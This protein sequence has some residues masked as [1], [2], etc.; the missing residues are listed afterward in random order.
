[1]VAANG[2]SGAYPA[3]AWLAGVLPVEARRFRVADA[4]LADTL[5]DAGADLVATAPDVEIGAVRNLLGD[6]PMAIVSINRSARGKL[7]AVRAVKR[8]G[9]TL[10][11][12]AQARRVRRS[13]RARGYENVTV[14]VWDGLQA[15]RAPWF[16]AERGS[17]SAV[18]WMP[19]RALV[20]GLRAEQ[21]PTLLEAAAFAASKSASVPFWLTPPLV[22]AGVLV[23]VSDAILRVAVGPARREIE[24]QASALETLHSVQLPHSVATRVPR[25]F[26]HGRTG[27]ADWSLETRLAGSPPPLP[28]SDA[29]LHDCVDFLVDLHSV[30]GAPDDSLSCTALADTVTEGCAAEFVAPLRALAH[31]LDL[32]LADVPRGFAHADFFHGNLLVESGRLA[33]VIDWDGA[34]PGRCPLLRLLHLRFGAEPTPLADQWGRTVIRHAALGGDRR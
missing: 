19:Q 12:R 33:G 6:A 18:D 32:E 15:F 29:L 1:M 2:S 31:R 7:R 21:P 28:L 4:A 3:H 16:P 24:A 5:A 10:H 30:R 8:F 17:R 9:N 34:G 13:L 23:M 22:R 11:V 25:V 27:L 20:I 14:I 26:G